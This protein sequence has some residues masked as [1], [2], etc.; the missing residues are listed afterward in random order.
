M[1]EGDTADPLSASL[2]K[3]LRLCDR[4]AHKS[5]SMWIQGQRL[6]FAAVT[7]LPTEAPSVNGRSLRSRRLNRLP[8]GEALVAELDIS[9]AAPQQGADKL[10]SPL[11]EFN[12][13]MV[14]HPVHLTIDCAAEHEPSLETPLVLCT[15]TL[16]KVCEALSLSAVFPCLATE[17]IE[18]FRFSCGLFERAGTYE[19][20]HQ[21]ILRFRAT[22]RWIEQH[23][24]DKPC[25][26]KA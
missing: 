8:Q 11:P 2:D 24:D 22:W 18:P 6:F 13:I 10:S 17:K 21:C 19:V 1:R 26:G 12:G 4:A 9:G 16:V 5:S 14:G 15:K 20:S 25:E 7:Y 23:K 3:W